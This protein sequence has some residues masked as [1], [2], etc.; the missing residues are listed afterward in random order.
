MLIILSLSSVKEMSL[1]T[2]VVRV[3][4]VEFQERAVAFYVQEVPCTKLEKGPSGDTGV[5]DM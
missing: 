4:K 3:L 1:L 2:S 5:S